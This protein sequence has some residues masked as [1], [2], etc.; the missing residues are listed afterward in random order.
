MTSPAG[1]VVQSPRPVIFPAAPAT[2]RGTAGTRITPNLFGIATGIA[3]L[4]AVWQLAHGQGLVPGRP[5][6][7]LYLV[8]A[9]A[10]LVLTVAWAR[11]FGPGRRALADELRDPVLGPFVSLL[12]IGGMA[13]GVALS[14]HAPAAG[15]IVF[16]MFAVATLLLGIRLAAGWIVDPPPLR[17]VHSGYL[18]PMVAGGLIAAA[19][20]ARTG[21]AGAARVAFCIGL[22]CWAVL[23]PI[24]A[25]R[26]LRGPG[27]RRR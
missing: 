19:G 16:G 5:A 14:T 13:L 10:W 26:L 23:G 8:A 7:V 9:I 27:C 2:A 12:P 22:F 25:A 4:A 6:T 20:F 24:V 18:L 11:Q 1:T 17:T 3:A 15:R 21:Q